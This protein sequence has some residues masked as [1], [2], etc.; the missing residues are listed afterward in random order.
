MRISFHSH[1][2]RGTQD[3]QRTKSNKRMN[4]QNVLATM[5][6]C[7]EKKRNSLVFRFVP[8]ARTGNR[9]HKSCPLTR[10]SCFADRDAGDSQDL[11]CKE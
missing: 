10:N 7:I 8:E 5:V 6:S 2:V 11:R 9:Q 1:R 4:M 3:S